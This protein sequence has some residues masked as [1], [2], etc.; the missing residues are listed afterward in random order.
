MTTILT[1]H[2]IELLPGFL[3]PEGI[4]VPFKVPLPARLDNE[5]IS[6]VFEP[7]AEQ[8]VNLSRVE[9]HEGA[10]TYAFDTSLPDAGRVRR[11]LWEI[12]M[13]RRDDGSSVGVTPED[14]DQDVVAYKTTGFS[15]SPALLFVWQGI[16]VPL[17]EEKDSLFLVLLVELAQ[18]DSVSRW[19]TWV[20]RETGASASI[21]EVN[22]PSIYVRGPVAPRPAE[23]HAHAQRRSRILVPLAVSVFFVRKYPNTPFWLWVRDRSK[24]SMVTPINQQQQYIVVYAADPQDSASFRRML[25]LGTEDKTGYH[26]RY[27]TEGILETG[28]QAYFNWRATNIPGFE[29]ALS[30]GKPRTEWGNT[31]ASPYPIVVGAL[32]AKDD[33]FWY[34]AA[35]FYK[36]FI[37]RSGMWDDP[38]LSPNVIRPKVESPL[39]VFTNVL[40]TVQTTG[41]PLHESI[42]NVARSIQ[43]GLA[44]EHTSTDDVYLHYHNYRSEGIRIEPENPSNP[45]KDSFDDGIVGMIN[46]GKTLGF[47]SSLYHRPQDVHPDLGWGPLLPPELLAY[48]RNHEIISGTFGGYLLDYGSPDTPRW[49]I[50]HI[51][52]PWV[53]DY[54]LKSLYFDNL[55]GGIF[56]DPPPPTKPTNVAHGG[57][58]NQQ[59]VRAYLK[60][61]RNLFNQHAAET[62]ARPEEY[63]LIGEGPTEHDAQ[64]FDLTNVGYHP[65]ANQLSLAEDVYLTG[66]DGTGEDPADYADVP[67]ASRSMSPP[68]WAAAHGEWIPIYRQPMPF[69]NI[70]LE[71]NH[72]FHPSETVFLPGVRFPGLTSSEFVD[73]YCYVHTLLL[74]EGARPSLL[75]Y[76]AVVDDQPQLWEL[77]RDGQVVVD[78]SVD[79]DGCGLTIRDFL[80]LLHASGKQEFLGQFLRAGVAMRPLQIDFQSSQVDLAVN[81][82]S[83]GAKANPEYGLQVNPGPY[84]HPL[85]PGSPFRIGFDDY[86]VPRVEHSVWESSSGNL[87][88]LLVNWSAEEASWEGRFDPVLY[89]MG[90]SSMFSVEELRIDGAALPK[91][92]HSGPVSITTGAAG[93]VVEIGR[94]EPRSVRLFTIKRT[95]P[96]S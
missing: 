71:T 23:S 18:G 35:A 31:Y 57:D 30:A 39:L 16:R 2:E 64:Y 51:V 37:K 55:H 8:G 78:R 46:F 85:L 48:D 21:D 61:I 13:T 96:E 54:G 19:H 44:N 95:M 26:K 34:D 10:A 12:R 84:I 14:S 93:G 79:P 4:G 15:G 20:G 94:L 53:R 88:L 73:M 65:Y 50:D 38:S 41:L 74:I 6:V 69:S 36:E 76:Y 5:L 87:G 58:D 17:A 75:F 81:P 3:L 25:F 80:K 40:P 91:G 24:G 72:R 52:E 89:G 32:T 9:H 59:G 66:E 70:G 63:M 62:G 22:C 28:D 27:G 29:D 82:V 43:A 42:V 49:F 86:L 1:R 47:S 11:G 90:G 67:A 33:H 56:Y 83:A 77:D 60:N 45:L 92:S 68:L 7:D